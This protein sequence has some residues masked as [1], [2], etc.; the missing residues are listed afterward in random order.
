M[1]VWECPNCGKTINHLD[2]MMSRYQYPCIKCRFP[3][4]LFKARKLEFIEKR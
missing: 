3:R 4:Q 2:K 1:I